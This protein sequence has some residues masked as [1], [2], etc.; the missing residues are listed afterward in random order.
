LLGHFDRPKLLSPSEAAWVGEVGFG[1]QP[2]A[3]PGVSESAES[4][5]PQEP[6]A[7]PGADASSSNGCS[8]PRPSRNVRW[9]L[10]W[11]MAVAVIAIAT[12][13]LTEFA[14]LCAAQHSLDLA[15][16]AGAFA[17]TLPR[18]SYESV[19]IAIDRKL[20]NDP[21]LSGKIQL[22]VLQ[23]GRPVGRQIHPGESDRIS[24][25]LTAP[26]SSVTPSWLL[27]LPLWRGDTMLHACAERSAPS[28]KLRP[29]HS[30]TAAE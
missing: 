29:E 4:F 19:A 28:H 25:T 18:A 1:R 22:T 13:Q 2:P 11:A 24:V 5:V 7:E 23:N 6:P 20:A 27:K 12:S 8:Q 26:A 16:R 30:Q 17:A 9:V 15:A 10:K 14:Y 3:L 21:Q